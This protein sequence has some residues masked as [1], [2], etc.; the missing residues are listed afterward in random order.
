[1]SKTV[2]SWRFLDA[3]SRRAMKRWAELP[4]ETQVPWS[5]LA[6]PLSE[7]TVSL[8][9][10]A[11]LS[12]KTDTPFDLEIERR[13][14]WFADP[15]HRLLPRTVRTGGVDV[16]HLHINPSFAQRDLNSVLPLEWLE[17]L[18]VSRQ[19]ASVAPSHYSYVG[20][21]LRPQRLLSETVPHIVQRLRQE[22]VDVV[23]LVPV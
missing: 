21:T 10:S 1:M 9:S 14:P 4:A 18:A 19:I 8:V 12:A 15:S 3:I 7:C 20:Y 11:A 16:S 23:V 6:K 5:P 13:D 2:D 17:H 22:H